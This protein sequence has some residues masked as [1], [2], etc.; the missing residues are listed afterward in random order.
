M[1]RK[2]L[3]ALWKPEL[4]HGWGRK[5]SFFEGWY[6]KIVSADEKHAFAFIPGIAMDT[7]GKQQAFVQV[8]DGKKL[9]AAY[10]QFKGSEFIAQ[11]TI[12][13][14][15]V[16]K[17]NFTDNY[18]DLNLPHIK[19]KIQFENKFA[20]PS[21]WFSPGIMGPFSFAPR[22]ECK[23][24]ILSMDN[25]LKGE[26]I[27]DNERVDFNEGRGYMEKDWGHSFPEGYIW[28]QCNHF[29]TAGVSIKASV[30]KVPW[31]GSSF[32]GFIAGILINGTL[33]QFTTY[34]F[35]KLRHCSVEATQI[36]VTMENL[37]HRLEII[38]H[39]ERATVLAAP[40]GGFM[41]AR[42]EESMMARLDVKLTEKKTGD[43]I[44]EDTGTSAGLEVAGKYELLLK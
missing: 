13:H 29:S 12:H 35:T 1:M 38:A 30:A 27:I 28:M 33:Y 15:L 41:D 7:D 42:I 44:F 17:S 21:S 18:I 4:Y 25:S 5:K 34:N 26:L 14:V 22:M 11:P 9:T 2:R 19:G 43:I 6:Y 8:L 39:R 10:H 36:A 20:W 23:H 24:G 16:G 40:I 37:K 32:V 3:R 31:M